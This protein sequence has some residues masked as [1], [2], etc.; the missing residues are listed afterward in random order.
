MG[1]AFVFNIRGNHEA[2]FLEQLVQTACAELHTADRIFSLYKPES[3]LSQLA[4]GET[5]VAK[6][7]PVV[8]EIWDACEHW[9][10]QTDGWFSAFTPQHTFDPSGLVKTWAAQKAANVLLEASVSDFTLNAGGDILISEKASEPIDWRVGIAKPV[11]IAADDFGILTVLDLAGTE[12]RGV[13]NSGSAERGYHIWNPKSPERPANG[14]LQ[15]TAV[16]KDLVTADVWA[17]AAFAMGLRA[18]QILNAYNQSHSENQVQIL[19]QLPDGNLQ[20]TEGFEQL[21]ASPN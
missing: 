10:K 14:L 16:A 6:C 8:S 13:A 19:L 2:A 3:A 11:S 15:V 20:A 18:V 12:F 1:T 21:F 7:P 17:T 9:E 4:R 5:T